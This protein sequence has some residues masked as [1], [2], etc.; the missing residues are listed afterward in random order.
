[1]HICHEQQDIAVFNEIPESLRIVLHEEL[2]R[3]F[4]R[5]AHIFSGFQEPLFI[6]VMLSWFYE[7][8]TDAMTDSSSLAVMLR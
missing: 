1:M 3:D 8:D 5:E 2:Y 6:R 7:D 4:F